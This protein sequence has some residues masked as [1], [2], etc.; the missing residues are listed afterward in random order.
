MKIKIAREQRIIDALQMHASFIDNAGLFHGKMGIALYFFHLGRL[1]DREEFTLFAEELLDEVIEALPRGLPVDFANGLT[2]IGWAVEYLIRN[3]FVD[4]DADEVLE[5]IDAKIWRVFIHEACT[6]DLIV[7]TGY[8]LT[9]RL[10]YRADND[11]DMKALH[12]KY[13]IIL[14]ADEIERQITAGNTSAWLYH[15]LTELRRLNVFNYKVEK[16]LTMLEKDTNHYLIPC[17]PR[18]TASEVD[19]IMNSKAV[20]SKYAGFDMRRIPVHARWGLKHGLAGFG[21]QQICIEHGL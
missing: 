12:M 21:L 8:Y 16:L 1:T 10:S 20:K 14:L 9:S 6:I 18:L 7:S 4:A 11:E 19:R 15:L 17:I 13:L 3:G 2:G 5:E